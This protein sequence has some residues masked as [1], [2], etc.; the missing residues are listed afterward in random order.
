M[1]LKPWEFGLLQP[2]EFFDLLKGSKWRQEIKE[3]TF[4]Y[5]T[6]HIMNMM[7]KY[8]KDPISPIV[9]LKPLRENPEEIKE[10]KKS[11]EEFLK[12]EFKMMLEQNK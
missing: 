7:G 12:E 3:D 9:L 5:F 4:A 1:E 2:H 11:D 6:C 10:K 8:L